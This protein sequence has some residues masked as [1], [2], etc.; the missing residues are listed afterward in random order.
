[1]ALQRHLVIAASL[2]L[3]SGCT[4]G[5]RPAGSAPP[6]HHPAPPPPPAQPR[7]LTQGEAEH[8][9]LKMAA[10][11]GYQNPRFHQVKWQDEHLQWKIDLRG[12]V[13]GREA[14]LQ[15]RIDARDGRVVDL[16]DKRHGKPDKDEKH[17]GKKHGK[18]HDKDDDDGD[19]D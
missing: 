5:I 15:M 17:E 1:M 19:D 7:L 2:L 6:P 14:K 10:E 8:I 3:L 13:D 4:L 16:K 12:G 18:G 11:R 9:A